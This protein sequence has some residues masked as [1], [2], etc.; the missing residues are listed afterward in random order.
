[1]A[2]LTLV[3]QHTPRLNRKGEISADDR[4]RAIA[5]GLGMGYLPQP[6]FLLLALR[7]FARGPEGR[8]KLTGKLIVTTGR[9]RLKSLTRHFVNPG[10]QCQLRLLRLLAG[11][12]SPSD[13]S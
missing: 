6:L 1:M 9:S 3:L 8:S 13:K 11:R 2:A 5:K 4:I 10:Q 7:L 12:F